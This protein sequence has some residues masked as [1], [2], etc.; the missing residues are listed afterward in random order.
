MA[1]T[2]KEMRNNGHTTMALRHHGENKTFGIL[3]NY[4]TSSDLSAMVTDT[5][6]PS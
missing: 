5:I 4:H 3:A 2:K 6:T 1:Y